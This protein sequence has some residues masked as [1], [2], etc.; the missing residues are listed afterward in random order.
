M[1]A[2]I[3][4][5]YSPVYWD[6]FFNDRVFNSFNGAKSHRKSPAVNIVEEDKEFR[7]EVALPGLARKDFHIEV[8]QDVLTLSSAEQEQKEEKQ[9]NYTRRE[10]GYNGF[11]RS[12]QLPD[13]IDQ[14]RIQA[15]YKDGMLTI[16]LVK[17]EEVLQ[18]AP[19]Q[20]EVK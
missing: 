11:K 16:M 6:D 14:D 17:K 2:R 1:L 20:I 12:F 8:E 7:I 19:R 15:K 5:N 4:R 18:K 13:T 9:E 10:F 3:N